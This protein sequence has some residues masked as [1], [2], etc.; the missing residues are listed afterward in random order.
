MELKQKTIG[1]LK[2]DREFFSSMQN[3]DKLGQI[4]ELANKEINYENK[5]QKFLELLKITHD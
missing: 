5:A 2:E 4:I 1:L 3:K